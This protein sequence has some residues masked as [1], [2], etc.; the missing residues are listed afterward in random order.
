MTFAGN[1]KGAVWV[2]LAIFA[3][4]AVGIAVDLF[5]DYA[6]GT[7]VAHLAAEA[8]VL[9]LSTLGV[10][11]LLFRLRALRRETRDLVRTLEVTRHDAERWRREAADLLRGLGAAIDQ[12]FERWQLTPAER[13][14]GLLLL[15]GLS[16]KE[17]AEVRSVSERTVRQQARSLYA[18]AGVSGRADL[19]A[20]FLEDLLLPQTAPAGPASKA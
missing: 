3:A 18:K 11:L 5:T 20:F 7:G 17:I 9:A 12:Q 4:V 2:G 19:A 6:S 16:H 15:K 8:A 13:E 14:V 10:A 1:E